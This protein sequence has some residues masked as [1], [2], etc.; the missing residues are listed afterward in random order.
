MSL[1]SA[2]SVFDNGYNTIT[3]GYRAGNPTV[4]AYDASGDSVMSSIQPLIDYMTGEQSATNAYNSAEA[5]EQ[6]RFQAEQAELDRAFNAA[7]AQKSRDW[8][9]MMSD[10]AHQ[11]EVADLIAAG[12][13]PVLSA[14]GGNGASTGSG[15]TASYQA[16][17]SGAKATAGNVNAALVSLFGTLLDNQTKLMMSMNSGYATNSYYDTQ[18]ALALL[19]R[20]WEIEDRDYQKA[21]WTYQRETEKQ[22][23]IDINNA[24][25][26]T[27]LFGGLLQGI[28]NQLD[29]DNKDSIANY[30]WDYYIT[31]ITD[32]IKRWIKGSN[33]AKSTS[34]HTSSK[35]KF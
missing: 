7:E 28:S 13:N 16:G 23:Q 4:T 29:P 35:G 31:P 6:R 26:G 10:T 12:L 20:E 5:A 1:A 11:R 32:A 27:G 8:Q 25:P 24:K 14:S 22:N 15:A 19:K 3:S 21:Y 17:A 2:K 30:A 33:S 9:S 18:M 34:G